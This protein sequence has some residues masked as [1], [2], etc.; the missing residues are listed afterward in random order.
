[1]IPGATFVPLDGRAHPPWEGGS[2]PADVIAAFLA[3]ESVEIPTG[4]DDD[5]A[6]CRFDD[7]ARAVI[8]DGEPITLT[9]LE[10]GLLRYLRSRPGEVVTRDELLREVWE[11]DYGGS[12]VVDAAVRAVRRKLGEYAGAIET[13]KGHGY[14]FVVF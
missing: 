12:N 1:M 9:R 8:V 2:E 14:R 13:V 4:S 3:G 5:A 10:Y 6:G 7:G 11:Q